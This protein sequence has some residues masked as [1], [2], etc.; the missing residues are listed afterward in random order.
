[1]AGWYEISKSSKGE[2]YFVLKASN[3]EVILTS[4]QYKARAS[5]DNGIASV[6]TNSPDAGRY[7]K[8]EASNGKSFFN[9]KAGNHQVIGT[10]QMYATVAARDNG[11]K[12]V[13]SN[14]GSTKVKDNTQ[15]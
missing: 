2:F 11:I 4:E 6:R 1:M 3:G 12:S 9:L 5:A 15:S 14:G 13:M 8:K 7:E 10:S